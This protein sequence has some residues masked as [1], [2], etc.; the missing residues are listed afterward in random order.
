MNHNVPTNPAGGTPPGDDFLS[1]AQILNILWRR[2]LMIVL[3]TLLGLAAGIGYGVVVKPLYRAT[4]TV[5][6]GITNFMANGN[7]ERSWRIKDVVRWYRR[8]MYKTGVREAMGWEPGRLAPLIEAEF[9]PRGVGVQGG[10]VVTLT[11]LHVNQGESKQILDASIKVFNQYAEINS[12]G[13]SLSLERKNLQNQINQLANDRDNVDIKKDLLDI[14]IE[15]ARRELEQI[16]VEE[17]QLVLKVKEHAVL[18]QQRT[19]KADRLE[20][21]VGVVD[22]GL[23]DMDGV[24][25]RMRAKEA[26]QGHRDSLLAQ[27]PETDQLPF[28]WWQ[29]AQDKTAMTGRLLLSSL[30]LEAK[31]WDD[32]LLAVDLRAENK[33]SDL[34]HQA[35]LL[36]IRFDLLNRKELVN[37]TIR[38]KEINRDRT[39]A[40]EVVDI[41]DE[42]QL[43]QSRFEV[44]TSLEKV[45]SI[46]VSIN[47]VR[48]RKS[49]AAGLLTMAAFMASICLAFTWEYVSRNRSTIFASSTDD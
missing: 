21:G 29:M 20:A 35:N 47:P 49:R 33:A 5:R 11:M 13:N 10:N 1:L 31:I 24:L 44:L 27:I 46:D 30:E 32:Q 39:L 6:P 4:A 8:S 18:L 36:A 40:Q 12:V 25:E 45:G 7:P 26:R 34:A 23:D 22:R 37:L 16:D 42:I 14:A 19:D 15:R 28:L 2:R 41:D 48:P 43:L 3:L 9:I 38:E 17:R